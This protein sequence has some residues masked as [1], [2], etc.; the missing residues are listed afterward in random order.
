M[1]LS[2]TLTDALDL[3]HSGSDEGIFLLTIIVVGFSDFSVSYHFIT[4]GFIHPL[5][6][7]L[8]LKPGNGAVVIQRDRS[9]RNQQQTSNWDP[10]DSLVKKIWGRKSVKE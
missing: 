2:F 4:S 10:H 3:A 7:M 9:S 6:D 5:V 1:W 8:P